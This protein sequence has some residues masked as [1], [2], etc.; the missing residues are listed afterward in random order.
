MGL[1][2]K[3]YIKLENRIKYY[4]TCMKNAKIVTISLSPMDGPYPRSTKSLKETL[5][6]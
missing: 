5:M 1:I 2:M 3:N 6:D 4:L